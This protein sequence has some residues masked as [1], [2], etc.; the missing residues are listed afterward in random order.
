MIMTKLKPVGIDLPIQ[1]LQ[2]FLYVQLQKKWNMAASDYKCYGRAYRNQ[3]PDGYTPEVFL[4]NGTTIEYA[5]TLVDDT[6]KVNSFFSVGESQKYLPAH[7][8]IANVALIFNVTNISLIKPGYAYRADEE[9]RLDVEMLVKTPRFGFQFDSVETGIDNV[10]KEFSGWNK[11][12]G[13][14][15]MDM[16]PYHFFRINLVTQPYSVSIC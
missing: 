7:G 4:G 2:N 5:D 16:H 15:Y 3:T 11:K 13:I 6:C 12:K 1:A 9:V 8:M 10:F 14:Q